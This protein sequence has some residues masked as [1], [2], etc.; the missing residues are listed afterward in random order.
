M[1]R[2]PRSGRRLDSQNSRSEREE[3]EFKKKEIAGGKASSKKGQYALNTRN[4]GG[5]LSIRGEENE[6]K[7][8]K[9]LE[10]G[11]KQGADESSFSYKF[12]F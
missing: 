12:I 4:L 1:S 11:T 6:V 3:P 9:S 8:P 7:E 10:K 5:N 2:R